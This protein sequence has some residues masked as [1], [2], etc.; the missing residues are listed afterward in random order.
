MC[1][2]SVNEV[3]ELLHDQHVSEDDKPDALRSLLE[4][5]NRESAHVSASESAS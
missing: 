5:Y 2:Y 1:F 4:R 3:L